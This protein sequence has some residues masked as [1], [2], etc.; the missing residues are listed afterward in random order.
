MSGDILQRVD[1]AV[2]RYIACFKRKLGYMQIFN[3][4]MSV[5]VCDVLYMLI[6]ALSA[7]ILSMAYSFGTIRYFSLFSQ[8]CGVLFVRFTIGRFTVRFF[9]FFLGKFV[10]FFKEIL[11]KS[12]K[13][14][15]R[16]LQPTGVLLY[17]KVK[18]KQPVVTNSADS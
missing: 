2:H 8:I 17:N 3:S 13:S 12:K 15:K 4:R 1:F 5:F 11:I 14:I 6:F 9:G 16:V 7:A 10:A 18:K